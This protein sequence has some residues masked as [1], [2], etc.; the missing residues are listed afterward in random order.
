MLQMLALR[1]I[2]ER[3]FI[4]GMRLWRVLKYGSVELDDVSGM[5]FD[6]FLILS[7]FYQTHMKEYLNLLFIATFLSINQFQHRQF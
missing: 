1:L 6:E 2:K 4:L 3:R 7:S 5:V